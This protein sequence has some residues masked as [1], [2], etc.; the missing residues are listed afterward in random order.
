MKKHPPH[1]TRERMARSLALDPRI[2]NEFEFH[3][4]LP[5]PVE[6]TDDGEPLFHSSAILVAHFISCTIE[7]GFSVNEIRSLLST[8]EL[9]GTTAECSGERA[10]IRVLAMR[11]KLREQLPGAGAQSDFDDNCSVDLYMLS[12]LEHTGTASEAGVPAAH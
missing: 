5:D 1:M 12:A 11:E 3:G 10:L 7:A 2:I 4:L 8:Y 6:T 9:L